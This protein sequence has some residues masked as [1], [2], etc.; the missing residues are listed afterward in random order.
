MVDGL[1]HGIGVDVAGAVA[2]SRCPDVAEQSGE[3]RLVAG[4]DPFLRGTPFG[5]G[6]HDAAVPRCGQAGRGPGL[7][8]VLMR[9]SRA[10]MPAADQR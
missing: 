1:V 7:A 3:L 10:A 4:A 5:F 2:A 6:G 8:A 9:G